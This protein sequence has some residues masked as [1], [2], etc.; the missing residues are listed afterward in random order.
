MAIVLH[1]AYMMIALVFLLGAF[2]INSNDPRIE[3][4]GWALQGTIALIVAWGVKRIGVSNARASEA[5]T[6]LAEVHTLVNS[7]S[8]AQDSKIEN[9]ESKVDGLLAQLGTLRETLASERATAIT[10][11]AVADVAAATE[12]GKRPV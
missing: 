5:N 6:K 12:P 7:R 11:Q 4:V 9:L 1:D 2:T 10:S 8:A 3:A